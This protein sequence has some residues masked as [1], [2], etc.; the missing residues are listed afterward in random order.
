MESNPKRIKL[1]LEPCIQSTALD[2]TET[3]HEIYKTEVSLPDQLMR[4]VNCIWFERGDWKDITEED[5]INQ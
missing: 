5:L 2:I 3:G 1:S 4:N